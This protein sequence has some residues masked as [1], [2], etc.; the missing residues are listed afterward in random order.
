MNETVESSQLEMRPMLASGRAAQAHWGRQ[1][2]THRTR[3]LRR[4]RGL[5]ASNSILLAQTAAETRDRPLAEKLASEVVPLADTC[6]WLEKRTEEILK[7]RLEKRRHRPLWLRGVTFEVH[8]HPFGIIL[9]VGPASYPLFDA[10]ATATCRMYR[11]GRAVW[12]GFAKN[13]H[14]GLASPF[15]I[16][17]ATIVLGAGQCV[18]PM[19]LLAAAAGTIHSAFVTVVS[20]LACLAIFVPR[21]CGA[22]RFRQPLVSVFLHPLGIAALIA[23]QWWVFVRRLFRPETVWKGRSYADILV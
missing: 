2:F 10:T 22:V 13:S 19:L 3:Y 6:R 5:I 9:V 23:L 8:R 14:E 17:P 12:P 18:P 1:S 20:M 4:L 7:P 15:L 11:S 16:G 21:L